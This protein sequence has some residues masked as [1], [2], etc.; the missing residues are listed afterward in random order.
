MQPGQALVYHIWEIR[1]DVL[2]NNKVVQPDN[3]LKKIKFAVKNRISV[4]IGE[5]CWIAAR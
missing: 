4:V 5:K 2:Q 1:N 3:I